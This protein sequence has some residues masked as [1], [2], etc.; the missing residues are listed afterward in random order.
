MKPFLKYWLP[1]IL[2]CSLIFWLSSIQHL[3]TG[4]GLWDFI[5]RKCAHMAEYG[6][7]YLL[8][9]R[10]F[11]GTPSASWFDK[12]TTLSKVEGLRI[13]PTMAGFVFAVLYAASDEFH[14]S[15]VPTR[16][17]SVKDVMLDAAGAYIALRLRHWAVKL[18]NNEKHI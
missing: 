10:A 9:R 7:L 2:W 13:N 14:Q 11:A 6:V 8:A 18:K 15:F 17:P 16:G 4:W 5:L 1:V 3:D 12:L